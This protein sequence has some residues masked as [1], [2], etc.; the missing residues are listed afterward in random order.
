MKHPPGNPEEAGLEG[1]K[2]HNKTKL[3]TPAVTCL[4]L[5]SRLL[6]E[7]VVTRHGLAQGLEALAQL[8]AVPDLILDRRAQLIAQLLPVLLRAGLLL[9]DLVPELLLILLARLFHVLDPVLHTFRQTVLQT[10]TSAVLI[11]RR[12]AG[13]QFVPVPLLDLVALWTSAGALRDCGD[14][15][16]RHSHY[17]CCYQVSFHVSSFFFT[18]RLLC[19]ALLMQT[20]CQGL[21]LAKTSMFRPCS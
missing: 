15:G 7:L 20:A 18:R 2:L 19:L 5:L 21:M 6:H 12:T 17:Q 10:C 9:L 11:E 4:D 1:V 13:L 16:Q 3:L 14:A 8:L